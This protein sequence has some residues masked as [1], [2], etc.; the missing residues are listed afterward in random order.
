M[1]ELREFNLKDAIYI[2]ALLPEVERRVYEKFSG[3]AYRADD[4]AYAAFGGIGPKWVFDAP[5]A[6]AAIGGFT[7]VTPGTYRTW[8]YATARAWREHGR[9]LTEECAKLVASALTV[10]HRVETVTLAEHTKAR[11]WYPQIGLREESTL[12][13]YGANGEDAVMFVALRGVGNV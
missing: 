11:Q 2:C 12:P 7:P 13:G 10:A 6:P 9:E 3:Q 1:I 5:A 8:F 4:A